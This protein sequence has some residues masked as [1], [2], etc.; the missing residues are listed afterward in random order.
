MKT[1]LFTI[2]FI[3]II[4][5]SKREQKTTYN[6]SGKSNS[7]IS[8][9]N[10]DTAININK[11]SWS[12]EE[13]VSELTNG[14]LKNTSGS[15]MYDDGYQKEE[16]DYSFQFIDL[17]E[18]GYPEVFRINCC[19]QMI[20]GLMLGETF[21]YLKDSSGKWK[22][23]NTWSGGMYEFKAINPS[24]KGFKDI[25]FSG[26]FIGANEMPD[27][28]W[29]WNGK[30]Y[31]LLKNLKHKYQEENSSHSGNFPQAL[32]T[33]KNWITALGK[34]DFSTAYY[35]MSPKARGDYNKFISTK[36]YGGISKTNI[37]S[38]DVTSSSGCYYEVVAVYDSYDPSNRDGKFTQKFEVSN[39]DG[40][41]LITS[42][43]NMKVEYFR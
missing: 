17:N 40:S 35:T 23:I 5:C 37:H 38:V 19:S 16:I 22:E 32:E 8:T 27:A 20:F 41:W 12:E 4:G 43:K 3:L 15:F 6:G 13:I 29:R 21:L 31:D 34:Q 28:I 25:L 2:L 14:K 24:H 11:S 7:V 42:V 30:Q 9:E 39:C 1:V 33:V 10:Q 26:G 18:D 36:A